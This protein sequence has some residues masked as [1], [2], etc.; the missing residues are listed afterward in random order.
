MPSHPT[1][2][3]A[4]EGIGCQ[5]SAGGQCHGVPMT[6]G[7]EEALFVRNRLGG[8]SEARDEPG[9]ILSFLQSPCFRMLSIVSD[10]TAYQSQIYTVIL[11][12]RRVLC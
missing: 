6:G 4:A 7:S 10:Y 11:L 3:T 5:G 9:S 1:L 2:A 12:K 8:C